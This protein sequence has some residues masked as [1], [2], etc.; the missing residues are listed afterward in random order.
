MKLYLPFCFG[1]LLV[2]AGLQAQTTGNYST[3]YY[4]RASLF[5]VLPVDSTDI[6]FVGNSI[7]DGSEW[8]ELFQNPRVKNRGIS[9]DTTQGIYDRLDA[10]LKGHPAQL[11]LLAGTNNVPRG[12]SA[13]SIAEGIRRIVQKIKRQSPRT[14]ILVQSLLPVTPHYG[15]FEGHTSRWQMIPDI[16]RAIRKVTQEEQ[17][18]FIDLFPHFSDERGQMKTIYTNDGLHLLGNGYLH[19]KEIIEPYIHK[20]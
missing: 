8:H 13:D 14:E 7:T 1:C 2:T 10:I 15:M 16:N 5:D 4:Q 19:W 3:Y 11:F 20:Q 9:G 18:T 17:V 6:V 12:E